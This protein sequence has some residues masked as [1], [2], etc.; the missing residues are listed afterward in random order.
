MNPLNFERSEFTAYSETNIQI[1]D[2][3]KV[4]VQDNTYTYVA[5]SIKAC[6]CVEHFCTEQKGN[7]GRKHFH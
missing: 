5:I 6:V 4:K 2:I 7:G 3:K 1:W